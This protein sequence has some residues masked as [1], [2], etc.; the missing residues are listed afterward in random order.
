[1]WPVVFVTPDRPFNVP[2]GACIITKTMPERD[3]EYC[4]KNISEPHERVVRE[5]QMRIL[6][7]LPKSLNAP[8]DFD[9][10]G[11]SGSFAKFTAMRRA[12]SLVSR[13]AAVRRPGSRS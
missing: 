8:G 11:K 5:S 1:V 3:G 13:L 2:G 10:F 6:V 4:V 7:E 12:S 9:C